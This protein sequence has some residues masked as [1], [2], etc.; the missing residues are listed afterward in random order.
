VASLGATALAAWQAQRAARMQRRTAEQLVHD[1][2]AFAAWSYQRHVNNALSEAAWQV[3]N[4]IL[5]REVHSMPRH[6]DAQ[7]LV[8]Y[9]QTSLDQ[10]DCV[11]KFRPASFFGFTLG[12]DTFD[13]TGDALSAASRRWIRD[14]LDRQVRGAHLNRM[15]LIAGTASSPVPLFAYGLMPTAAGD[16]IVYGF[17]FDPKSLPAVFEDAFDQNPVLPEAVTRG[18][19]NDSIMAVRVLTADGR[20]LFASSGD[21]DWGYSARDTVRTAAGRLSVVAAVRPALVHQVLADSRSPSLLL[22]ALILIAGAL[23]VVAVRQLRRESEL[24]ELRTDFVASV[25]HELRTP[26]AQ[27]RLFIETLRLR[28]FATEEQ[29]EWLL[30]HLD[31]ETRRLTHLVENVLH[32]SR[33]AEQLTPLPLEPVDLAG[34]I[35]ETVRAFEPLAAARRAE[36]KQETIGD[37]TVPIDQASFRQLLL[38]LLDNA[39]KYGPVG[40]TVSVRAER[41]GDTVRVT[42][43]DQG[44]GVA[45]SDR[46]RVWAPYYRG[47]DHASR[48]VGGSGIGLA[49][50]RSVVE[51]HSGRA[52]LEPAGAQGTRVVVEFPAP[53][54]ARASAGSAA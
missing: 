21:A 36:L 9:Y 32:F 41:L 10:C 24:A 7:S 17:T 3:L 52:W 34:E 38:N 13:V 14:T 43:S 23:T 6:P 50:V 37:L 33:N 5:H 29:R 15:A 53:L 54:P 45:E 20:E 16:T 28:R 30:G 11:T 51:R 26:L 22:A 18:L 35:D 4:P 40:Q 49:V 31:R 8:R 12:A 19:P 44:P 27:L 1:Y 25:S 48:A 42:V 46:E 39:V 47:R 2:A